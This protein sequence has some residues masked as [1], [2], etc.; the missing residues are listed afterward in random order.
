M[1]SIT[2]NPKNCLCET[3]C[4]AYLWLEKKWFILPEK[5][6]FLLVG[7]FNTVLGYAVLNL[8]NWLAGL[9]FNRSAIYAANIAL[10]FHNCPTQQS[11]LFY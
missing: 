5:V 8:L 7:G 2:F 3:I 6:R 10:I 1:A 9:L 11:T 4:A